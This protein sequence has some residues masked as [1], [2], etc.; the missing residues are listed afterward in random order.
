MA[1]VSG[2]ETLAEHWGRVLQACSESGLSGREFA[3]R[4]GIGEST[5]WAWHR[6]LRSRLA[7]VR[8]QGAKPAV[9]LMPMQVRPTLGSR[10]GGRLTILVRGGRRIAV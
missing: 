6:C 3:A 9:S 1:H 4:Q 7:R 10:H 5:L 8:P 2:T